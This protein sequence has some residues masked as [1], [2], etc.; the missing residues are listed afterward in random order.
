MA[1]RASLAQLAPHQEWTPYSRRQRPL[2]P[3]KHSFSPHRSEG[4]GRAGAPRA[5]GLP[6]AADGPLRRAPRTDW[7]RPTALP[8]HSGP[9]TSSLP[10]RPGLP[11]I[12]LEDPAAGSEP[13]LGHD[14]GPAGTRPRLLAAVSSARWSPRLSS[15]FWREAPSPRAR[16]QPQSFRVQSPPP[17]CHQAPGP[18][19]CLLHL[20]PR[21]GARPA[22]SG[23]RRPRQPGIRGAPRRALAATSSE[24]CRSW[25]PGRGAGGFLEE[26]TAE[27]PP[28]HPRPP[29]SG[30]PSGAGAAN[31]GPPLNRCGRRPP[32]RPEQCQVVQRCNSHPQQP[33]NQPWGTS[34]RSSSSPETFCPLRR[35]RRCV[36]VSR[37][38][39]Q[40]SAS[41]QPGSAAV[42]DHLPQREKIPSPFSAASPPGAGDLQK[43]A[44]PDLAAARFPGTVTADLATG[45]SPRGPASARTSFLEK[46]PIRLASLA[47]RAPTSVWPLQSR[48]PY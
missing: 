42:L 1:I 4:L 5:A 29:I 25:R 41:P 3:A 36:S 12:A 32:L 24:T 28:G 30:N 31:A 43:P 26:K 11:R 18:S 38:L 45:R 21:G 22:A 20:R 40:A 48:E 13:V 8:L 17:S 44:Q 46:L 37:S 34:K 39:V 7:L 10:L 6:E 14:A 2:R 33:P 23:S 16:A 47:T 27:C 15:N 9:T 35:R 19:A